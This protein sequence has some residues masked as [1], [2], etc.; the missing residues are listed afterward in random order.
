MHTAV[1][2][3]RLPH[4]SAH[5]AVVSHSEFSLAVALH[6]V[7]LLAVVEKGLGIVPLHHGGAVG[8]TE[9]PL[10]LRALPEGLLVLDLSIVLLVLTPARSAALVGPAASVASVG[11]VLGT[12]RLG[13]QLLLLRVLQHV[14]LNLHLAENIH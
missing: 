6:R 8:L 2:L 14:D 4:A 11:A 13:L 7:P 3:E 12:T 9:T 5:P 10:V 1:C